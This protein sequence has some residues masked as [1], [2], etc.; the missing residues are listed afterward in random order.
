MSSTFSPFRPQ[1]LT[2]L[3]GGLAWLVFFKILD[4]ETWQSWTLFILVVAIALIG[5]MIQFK[6]RLKKAREEMSHEQNK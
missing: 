4:L 1:N 5:L 6:Y 2:V 3:L